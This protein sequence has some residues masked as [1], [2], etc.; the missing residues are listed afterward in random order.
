MNLEDKIQIATRICKA[1][2]I[3]IQGNLF[4]GVLLSW[5]D[6]ASAAYAAK[7]IRDSSVVTVNINNANFLRPVSIGDIISIYAKNTKIKNSSINFQVE[8]CITHPMSNI[9]LKAFECEI[10]FVR[11]AKIGG[12]IKAVKIGI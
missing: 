12:Q 8:V 11:I 10:T 7:T 6:E 2:D 9:E 4:G 1:S 3:G 5:V